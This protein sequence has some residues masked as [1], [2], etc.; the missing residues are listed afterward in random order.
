MSIIKNIST[1]VFSKGINLAINILF[2]P[3]LS[4]SLTINDYGTY[5]QTLLIVDLVKTLFA[6]GLALI[7]FVYLSQNINKIKVIS[8]NFILSLIL[9]FTGFIILFFSSVFLGQLFN[10]ENVAVGIA[11]YSISIIFSIP[12]TVLSSV[13]IYYKK[14]YT[15][16]KI[17]IIINVLRLAFLFISITILN[18]LVAVYVSLVILEL[19]YFLLLFSQLKTRF[20]YSSINLANGIRQFKDGFFINLATLLGFLT[21]AT[22]SLMI[23]IFKNE[24]AY[25]IYKNGAFEVPLI[26]V[27]YISISQIF[28]PK[29][30]QW[31]SNKDYSQIAKTKKK[32]SL[33][34]ASLIYPI[35]IFFVLYS[36]DFIT[37]YL[38]DRY[39]GSAL[40][41]SIFNLSLIMRIYDYLDVL[42]AAK[43]T[44]LILYVQVF[45]IITNF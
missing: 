22:D 23:S 39:K 15:Y 9:G 1:L 14:I 45:S 19:L 36:S 43:K 25:A 35:C 10:N 7:I 6:G 33:N 42:I 12:N 3:Y 37:V 17:I 29:I 24:N 28:L 8:S 18:S 11:I 5:G 20:K 31:Y 41:F 26:S 30:T 27:I 32:L 34:I 38:S 21:L 13:L 40:I 2:L 4:R 44:K 16:S